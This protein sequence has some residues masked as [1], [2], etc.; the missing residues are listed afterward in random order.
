MSGLR[1][2]M[3]KCIGEGYTITLRK[4]KVNKVTEPCK[5][6]LQKQM[7]SVLLKGGGGGGVTKRSPILDEFALK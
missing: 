4:S 3:Y 5:K 2:P 1:L 6:L 7:G